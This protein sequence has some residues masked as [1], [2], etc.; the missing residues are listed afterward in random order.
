MTASRPFAAFMLLITTGVIGVVYLA[1]YAGHLAPCEM[2]LTEREPWWV[3]LVVAFAALA[4]PW[5]W[6]TWALAL[7]LAIAFGWS[8]YL[9]SSHVLVEHHVAAPTAC[10]SG[11]AVAQSLDQMKAIILAGQLVPCDEPAW[12]AF[13]GKITLASLNLGLSVLLAIGCAIVAFRESGLLAKLRASVDL[14]RRRFAR[15]G[16]STL[17]RTAPE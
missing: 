10:S 15:R 14:V 1:Q 13:H 5:R 3:A 2:C 6:R 9:A 17:F 16:A 11:G 7:I 12:S 4:S 8:T